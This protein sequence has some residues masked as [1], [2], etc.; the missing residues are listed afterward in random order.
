MTIYLNTVSTT[1]STTDT[2]LATTTLAYRSATGSVTN[3]YGTQETFLAGTRII[4]NSAGTVTITASSN[5][6]AGTITDVPTVQAIATAT[7]TIDTKNYSDVSTYENLGSTA[8]LNWS[9]IKLTPIFKIKDVVGTTPVTTLA[10][11]AGYP[12]STQSDTLSFILEGCVGS[13]TVHLSEITGQ[14]FNT[15]ALTTAGTNTVEMGAFVETALTSIDTITVGGTAPLKVRFANAIEPSTITVSSVPAQIT[16]SDTDIGT[17]VGKTP[18]ITFGGYTSGTSDINMIDFAATSALALGSV[19][20]FPATTSSEY[21]VLSIKTASLTAQTVTT[22]TL[23][24]VTSNFTNLN[25]IRLS[26]ALAGT[27]DH[28]L[29]YYGTITNFVNSTANPSAATINLVSPSTVFVGNIDKVTAPIAANGAVTTYKATATGGTLTYKVMGDVAGAAAQTFKT[30]QYTTLTVNY[31][32]GY[33]SGVLTLT[34][35]DTLTTLNITGGRAQSEFTM[36]AA[37]RSTALATVSASGF[38]GKFTFAGHASDVALATITGSTAGSNVITATTAA[39]TGTSQ[40]ITGSSNADEIIVGVGPNNVTV[41]LHNSSSTEGNTLKIA[42]NATTGTSKFVTVTDP[43][44]GTSSTSVDLIKFDK[45]AASMCNA[46]TVGFASGSTPAVISTA[47]TAASFKEVSALSGTLATANNAFKIT[48]STTTAL[49][50]TAAASFAFAG[51]TSTAFNVLGIYPD[52]GTGTVHIGVFT[53]NTDSGNAL[54]TSFKDCVDTGLANA[55]IA[56]LDAG[57]IFFY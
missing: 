3:Y 34:S 15:L 53:G 25:T 23:L 56:N 35:D 47:N 37:S 57:D 4:G 44:F 40:T 27:G 19:I 36:A 21:N 55:S 52:S 46:G 49:I 9:N 13:P 11:A 42:T 7:T 39:L 20:T 12:L 29:S 22:A 50:N 43:N 18:T 45:T 31:S 2:T 30:E 24:D 14:Q 16:L 28:D 51:D 54:M 17:V 48:T 6:A 1:S 32:E 33:S 38:L 10:F 5:V 26:N 8:I 41:T